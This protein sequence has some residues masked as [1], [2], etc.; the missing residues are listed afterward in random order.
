MA[1][2]IRLFM[3]LFSRAVVFSTAQNEIIARWK[4]GEYFIRDVEVIGLEDELQI[5]LLPLKA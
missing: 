2:K 1:G 5:R 3:K 4:C